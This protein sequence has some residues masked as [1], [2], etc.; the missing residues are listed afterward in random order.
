[1][2]SCVQQPYF[3]IIE[4]F[5]DDNQQN[6]QYQNKSDGLGVSSNSS[7]RNTLL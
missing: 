2:S 5:Q 1:M 4:A 6:E 3:L 7:H